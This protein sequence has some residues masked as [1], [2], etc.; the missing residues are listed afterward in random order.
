MI[1]EPKDGWDGDC[2]VFESTICDSKN[3]PGKFVQHA[4]R[5]AYCK[6]DNGDVRLNG[7]SWCVSDDDSISVVGGQSVG[8]R[9]YRKMCID[10][11]IIIEACDPFRSKNLL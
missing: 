2:D 5:D 10:G 6:E 8:S 1:T 7:E 3:N 11:R 4:C 9:S